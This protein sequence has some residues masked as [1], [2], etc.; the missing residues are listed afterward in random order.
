MQ[1]I[2]AIQTTSAPQAIGPYSQGVQTGQGVQAG[3]WLFISGQIPLDPVS[4]VVVG[5][6]AAQQTE[7]VMKNIQAILHAAGAKCDQL[8]KTTIYLV[9]MADFA[10]V[11]EVYASYLQPPYPARA[12]IAVAALPKNVRVEIE[13]VALLSMSLT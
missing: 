10:A 7:Q 2:I 4:G 8:V 9:D 11:N 1:P 6:N 12:T 13:A 3:Q 5:E